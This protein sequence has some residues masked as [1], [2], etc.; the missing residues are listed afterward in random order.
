MSDNTTYCSIGVIY[1]T[2]TTATPAS[3]VQSISLPIATFQLVSPLENVDLLRLVVSLIGRKHY[4]FIA[5]ISKSFHAAYL[6]E[7]PKNTTT[8]S[9]NAS[10]AGYARICWED[11]KY[12][13]KRQ[14]CKLSYSAARFGSVSA[15]QYLCSVRCNWDEDTC[16]NAAKNG[17]L[18]VLQYLRKNEIGRAHV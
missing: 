3:L 6:Q 8:T 10:T 2:T 11:L 1:V 13:S 14:Q 5:V 16:A 12:P 18:N 7:F 4:R 9:L 15:M 17:H